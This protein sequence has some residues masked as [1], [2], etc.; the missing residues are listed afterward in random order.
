MIDSKVKVRPSVGQIDELSNELLIHGNIF[1]EITLFGMKLY[2][3]I[4]R[5]GRRFAS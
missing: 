4:H 1:K 2:L 5:S 3:R